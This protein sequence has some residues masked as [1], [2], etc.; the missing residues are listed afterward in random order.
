MPSD[1]TARMSAGGECSAPVAPP[2]A[3]KVEHRMEMFGDVRIDNYYWLCDDSR[4]NPDIL[5]HL[6]QENAYT[7]SVMAGNDLGMIQTERR[8]H[9]G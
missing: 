4:S 6:R 2:A 3:K 1:S 7:D 5:S 9:F 8:S